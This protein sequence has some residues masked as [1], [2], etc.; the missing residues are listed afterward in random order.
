MKSGSKQ[1]SEQHFITKSM[2][3]LSL[4]GYAWNTVERD[5]ETK[6]RHATSPSSPLVQLY[7]YYFL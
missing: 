2:I 1:D 6:Q 5:A 3:T 7:M 4:P